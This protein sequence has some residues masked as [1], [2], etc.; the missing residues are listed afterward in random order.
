MKK[1]AKV[2]LGELDGISNALTELAKTKLSMKTAYRI[3]R[4]MDNL[5]KEFRL[6]NGLRQ[7]LYDEYCEKDEKGRF[8]PTGD[9]RGL[10]IKAELR[11]EFWKV[12]GELLLQEAEV[13]VW[14]LSLEELEKAEISPLD[15]STLTF[16][17]EE[18][19]EPKEK[20]GEK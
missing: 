15:V 19:S 2:K 5:G 20:E 11:D 13:E 12:F 18:P 6:F 1:V 16:M 14:M 4:T 17:L 10:K 9:G 8:V 7:K 3:S